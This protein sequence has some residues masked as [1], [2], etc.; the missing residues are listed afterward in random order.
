MLAIKLKTSV[1][2]YRDI[3]ITLLALV[4]YA[5]NALAQGT[6]FTYQ[7]RLNDGANPAN[8]NY[9]FRFYLR[10]A[11]T[12]GNAVGTTNTIAPVAA[13]NG[14]FTVTLDFGANFPGAARWLEI[15]VRTNGSVSAYATL[16]PRQPLL[17]APYAI[18]ASNLTGILPA[19]QLSGSL[20]S[21]Q[22]SGT[23]S[24]AVT[25]NNA[26]NAMSGNGSGLTSLNAANISGGTLADARLSS[27]VALRNATQTFTGV[28]T[29]SNV[30][31]SGT[32]T[33]GWPFPVAS[34]QNNSTAA[35]ASPALTLQAAGNLQD[36]AFTVR[37]TGI[38]YIARFGTASGWL[39]D[40]TTNG[41]LQAGGLIR[42]AGGLVIENRTSDPA[43]PQTGQ[44][45][46]R[47]DL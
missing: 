26:A 21:A 43:S 42:A 2:I 10:D 39:V 1:K 7:G 34:I 27:N 35:N 16:S 4:A 12:A 31:S 41:T 15:G 33:G 45:W 44:I 28:N 25:L 14:L 29:F 11:L 17:P 13:S 8:G 37:T 46:L 23:Y 6:A 24:G 38:G 18:T 3:P 19:T 9:D 5:G 20:A 32:A 36:G 30:L 40:I 47:T 22:L